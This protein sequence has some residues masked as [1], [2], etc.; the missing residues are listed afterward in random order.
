MLLEQVVELP[1]VTPEGTFLGEIKLTRL[2]S[3]LLAENLDTG[4][5]CDTD[6]MTGSR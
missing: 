2:L 5:V 4:P 1:G 6:A 3:K